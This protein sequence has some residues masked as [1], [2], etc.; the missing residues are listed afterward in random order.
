MQSTNLDSPRGKD[1]KLKKG[2][3]IN[4]TGK[5][6]FQERPQ[7]ISPGGWKKEDSIGHQYN[8]LIRLNVDDFMKW[9]TDNPE[10]KRTV[11]QELAHKAVIKA[12]KDL[13][14][15]KEVTDRTEGKA[16]Q[17][18][19]ITSDGDK[20]VFPVVRFIEPNADS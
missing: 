14:Y 7:D 18:T 9:E 11:A 12:R 8:M 1:G 16:T 17:H 20:I 3:V 2:A 19:D 5:G 15:L 10:S 6:G 13:A 4:P